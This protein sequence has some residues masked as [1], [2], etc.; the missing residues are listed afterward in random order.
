MQLSPLK[1]LKYPLHLLAIKTPKYL[2]NSSHANIDHIL[3]KEGKPF[4]EVNPADASN[5]NI[6]D[7]DE[8]KV[9]NQRGRVYIR[10]RISQKVMQGVVC[11]PQGYWP[12]MLKGG[13]SANALTDDLLTDLGRGGAIQE[14]K[15]EI[16]KV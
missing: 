7:G 3:K 6:G 13:S 9:Y 16:V 15:V 10:A 12:S 11:M 4:L 1:L 8:L 5:R 2:L 14:A